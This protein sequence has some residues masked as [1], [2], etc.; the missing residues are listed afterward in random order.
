MA[1]H[2][3]VNAT[4]VLEDAV[5]RRSSVLVEDGV[6][7]AVEPE[8]GGGAETVDL[9]GQFLLPGLVDLHADEI[10]REVEPRPGVRFPAVFALAQSDRR[11]AAAGITT[12]FHAISFAQGE[13]GLR[14]TDAA[15]GLVEEIA[16]LRGRS[17]VDHRA[18][19]R[20]EV[21]DPAGVPAAAR[22]MEAGLADLLSFMEHAPGRGQY[23]QPGSY[24]DYLMRRFRAGPAEVEGIIEAKRRAAGGAPARVATLSA[25]ARARSIAM[26]SHDDETGD[27]VAAAASLGVT[28]SEFPIT[29]E[30][31]RAAR[32]RGMA[33][34][35]GAPNI[36]RGRSQSGAIR[37]VEAVEAGLACCLCSDYAPG[38]LLPAVFLLVEQGLLDLPAAVRM[39]TR[40]AALAAGLADRGEIAA[41]RRADLIAVERHDGWPA[42]TRCWSGGREVLRSGRPP[43]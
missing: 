19:I 38:A 25:V 14:C 22:L 7:A 41:G 6:V 32:D 1:R 9:G 17:L 37:A 27:H 21:T 39:A 11:N 20:Y 4:V 15:A 23:G 12:V 10:E 28:I 33:T 42:V 8:S 16:G 40:R 2:H 43:V 13:L 3:L 36:L 26:A 30:A 5:L 18:H 29:S 24:R 35:F 34:V 31:A